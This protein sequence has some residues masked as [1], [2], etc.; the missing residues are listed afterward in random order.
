M[1]GRATCDGTQCGVECNAGYHPC[2]GR[3]LADDNV[4]SC[5]KTCGA[6]A[7]AP[8][9]AVRT[10]RAG[11]CGFACNAG[12]NLCQRSS[13]V[14][15]HYDF[16]SK[17][18]EGWTLAI[19]GFQPTDY[20]VSS[21]L[22]HGGTS[23]AYFKME[24]DATTPRLAALRVHLCDMKDVDLTNESVSAWVN[25]NNT[26]SFV[27]GTTVSLILAM[28]DAAGDQV[29]TQIAS[30]TLSEGKQWHYLSGTVQHER[31]A[32]ARFFV[33]VASIPGSDHFVG[34]LHIDDVA[35]GG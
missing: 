12:F 31:A 3:C 32:S 27:S 30:V 29:N 14:D 10:C 28:V 9:N 24:L 7:A 23:A 4:N 25:L 22:R 5:G 18:L 8:S 1:N 35:I 15:N 33:V 13:C 2:N 26:S 19:Q 16:E 11:S 20:G 21:T 34:S 6:C 17:T